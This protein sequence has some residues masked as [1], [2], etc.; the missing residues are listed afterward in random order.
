LKKKISGTTLEEN[1]QES[2]RQEEAFHA[3]NK[4]ERSALAKEQSVPRSD[5]AVAKTRVRAEQDTELISRREAIELTRVGHILVAAA[6]PV[7]IKMLAYCSQPRKFSEVVKF[8]RM[9]PASFQFHEHLLR[10]EGLLERSTKSGLIRYQT[11]STGKMVLEIIRGP[12]REAL[13]Q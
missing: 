7:R 10:S 1:A 12:F 9:N 2:E 4:A 8:Y 5:S 6:N 11:T 3:E 13:A